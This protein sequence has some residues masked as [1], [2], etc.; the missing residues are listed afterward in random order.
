V[1]VSG[2]VEV[3]MKGALKM[4]LLAKL[5]VAVGAVVVV[6]ALGAVGLAYRVTAQQPKQSENAL[7][8]T[9][10]TE[11]RPQAETRRPQ[12]DDLESLRLEIEALRKELRATKERVKALEA[13][14][15]RGGVPGRAEIRSATGYIAPSQIKR[16]ANAGHM[17][18]TDPLSEAE[19]AWKKLRERP[20]DKQAAEA[21]ERALKRL[22]ERE[23]PMQP[24]E[25]RGR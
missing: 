4:M 9:R 7:L 5:K 10:T 17:K 15:E 2:S 6:T 12:A 11:S 24:G 3:L 25:S 8:P 21:L 13:K 1:A 16:G 18:A 22:R 19:A 14:A 23:K 20:D